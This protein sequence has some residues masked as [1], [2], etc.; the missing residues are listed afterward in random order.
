MEKPR[1]H[2][3]GLLGKEFM[4]TLEEV[5]FLAASLTGWMTLG[6]SF[7]VHLNFVSSTMGIVMFT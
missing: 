1:G 3:S 4:Y 7:I 5:N 2:L 6:K